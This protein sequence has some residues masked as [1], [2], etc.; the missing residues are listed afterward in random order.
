MNMIRVNVHQAKT[1][2]S[3]LLRQVERGET[4]LI[5]RGELPVARLVRVEAGRTVRPRVGTPTTA[6][7]KWTADAFRPLTA[8]ELAEWGL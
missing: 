2:L 1:Q 7:V 6:G 3:R 4:V 5:S 8:K